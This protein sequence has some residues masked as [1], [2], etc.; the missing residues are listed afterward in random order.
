MAQKLNPWRRVDPEPDG[1]APG[2]STPAQLRSSVRVGAGC[3]HTVCECRSPKT[4]ELW[5]QVHIAAPGLTVIVEL[6]HDLAGLVDEAHKP[7][8]LEAAQ[9][10][11]DTIADVLGNLAFN[12]LPLRKRGAPDA[13]ND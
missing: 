10:I 8:Q 5:W 6:E 4:G 7:D 11:A 3:R 13:G 9:D 1:V 2:E 12:E